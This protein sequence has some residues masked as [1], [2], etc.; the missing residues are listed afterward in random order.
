MQFPAQVDVSIEFAHVALTQSSFLQAEVETSA[1]YVNSVI[2]RLDREDKSWSVCILID[3]KYNR[4]GI[5]EIAPFL[6]FARK[7]VLRLD[8][9]CFEKALPRYK[10]ALYEVLKPRVRDRIMGDIRRYSRKH[11]GIGCSHDIALWHLIRLGVINNLDG[12]TI[13]PV[14]VVDS[15][16]HGAFTHI[17]Q[18]VVSIL[19]ERD[20][21]FEEKAVDEILR[22]CIEPR[23]LDR[24][25]RIFY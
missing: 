5:R 10:E 22:Y 19:S 23:I 8:F 3:N 20:R 14:G 24:I 13:V 7:L 12:D 17:S 6:N 21:P 2:E 25:E 16:A 11:K 9:I 18:R 1:K 4:L 15:G